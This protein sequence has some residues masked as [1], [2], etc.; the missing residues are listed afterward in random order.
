MHKGIDRRLGRAVCLVALLVMAFLVVAPAS[1]RADDAVYVDTDALNL[2]AKPRT[3]S[4]VL[5]VMDNGEQLEVLSGPND[6]GWYKVRYQGQRGWAY[7]GYLS[8]SGSSEAERWIDVNRSSQTVTLYVGSEAIASFW[9]AMGWDDSADGFY[10]TAVGTYHVYSK[11][12]P[13]S[14]TDWGQAYITYWV[15]FDDVRFNGFHGYMMDENGN[16]LSTGDGP[17]GGCVALDPGDAQTLYEFASYG[18]R[19]EVHW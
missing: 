15:G 13:L 8:A 5:A 3:D 19:V 1:A 16:V 17:T 7:G 10:A 14:W 9:G 18:A 12:A 6:D 4:R 2:R 11:H